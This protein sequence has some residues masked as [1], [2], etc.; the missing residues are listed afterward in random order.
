[1][2]PERIIHRGVHPNPTWGAGFEVQH[3][4]LVEDWA[5]GKINTCPYC[6]HPMPP[7]PT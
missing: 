7:Y 2:T 3:Q 5:K 1:M 4:N 6:H